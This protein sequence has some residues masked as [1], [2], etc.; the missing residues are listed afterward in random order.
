VP[1][2]GND[3]TKIVTD[4]L[5]MFGETGSGKLSFTLPTEFDKKFEENGVFKLD[6]V[7]NFPGPAAMTVPVGLTEG[8]IFSISKEKP[9][10]KRTYPFRC[11]GRTYEDSYEIKFPEKTTIT[12]LP[13]GLSYS[14]DGYS[15]ESSYSKTK[16][17]VS[18]YKKMTLDHDSMTCKPGLESKKNAF[19]KVIQKDVRA[20]IFYE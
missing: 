13:E 15:Y 10:E 20:Q 16:N 7:S 6:P 19:F 12:R 1:N 11:F 5:S 8:R 17:I 3:D 18:V 9:L 2:V 4:M 14:A